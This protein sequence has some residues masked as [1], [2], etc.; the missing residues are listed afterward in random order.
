MDLSKVLRQLELEKQNI[1]QA[2]ALLEQVQGGSDVPATKYREP[3]GPVSLPKR[4]GRK[5]MGAEERQRVSERMM[6]YWENRRRLSS[7]SLVTTAGAPF[8]PIGA[9]SSKPVWVALRSAGPVAAR[10]G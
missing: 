10:I 7:Q 4:R 2:I 3:A 1:E 5:S 9:R 6:R 8:T